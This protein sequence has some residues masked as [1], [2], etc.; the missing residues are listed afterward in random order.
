MTRRTTKIA[1]LGAG[2]VLA[3]PALVAAG[4]PARAAYDTVTTPTNIQVDVGASSVTVSWEPS[5]STAGDISIYYVKLGSQWLWT[6]N[7]TLTL[8]LKP[9]W[10]YTLSVQAQDEAYNRSDWSDPIQFTTSDEPPVTTPANVQADDSPGSVTVTWEPSS[11]DAGVQEYVVSLHGGTI[12]HVAQRTSSTTAT[13]EVPHGGEFEVTVKAQDTAYRWS[14]TSDPILATVQPAQDWEPPSAP[15][16]FRAVP[17][18]DEI[19]F[20]WDAATGG[21]QPITYEI[22]LDGDVIDS[23]RDTQLRSPYFA[24]CQPWQTPSTFVV[25]ANSYGFE[26]PPSNPLELCFN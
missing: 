3:L 23:T 8:F 24:E 1:S 10:T 16:N 11:S 17:D 15:T 26:S 20:Q 5:M 6:E 22:A 9:S 4:V 13:F 2:L 19:V 21:A 14:A 18:G 7:P 25:T 12:G